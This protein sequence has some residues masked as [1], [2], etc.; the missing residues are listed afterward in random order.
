[1]DEFMAQLLKEKRQKILLQQDA[2]YEK[3]Q[4]KNMDVM[5]PLCKLWQNLETADKEQDSSVSINNLIKFVHKLQYPWDRQTLPCH[6]TDVSVL[7]M[8]L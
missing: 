6:T 4:R 8:V 1:M 7:L 5:G 3:V 2:I